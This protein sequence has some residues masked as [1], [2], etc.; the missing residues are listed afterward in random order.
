M[1]A[2]WPAEYEDH[3]VGI[4][5]MFGGFLLPVLMVLGIALNLYVFADKAVNYILI[6]DINPKS[7]TNSVFLKTLEAGA[8]LLMGWSMLLTFWLFW[9][10]ARFLAGLDSRTL[11]LTVTAVNSILQ[12]LKAGNFG[13]NP[14]PNLPLP[15]N[16]NH[17]LHTPNTEGR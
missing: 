8:W 17:E 2:T 10:G 3:K 7:K 1:V 5:A 11:L 14:S 9:Y 12:T 15:P 6:F 13:C 4:F 16:P